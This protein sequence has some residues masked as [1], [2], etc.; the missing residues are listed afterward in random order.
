M[1]WSSRLG[2][3]PL[4]LTTRVMTFV[5][6]AIGLSLLVIGYLVDNAVE[7]HFA[8]QDAGELVVMMNAVDNA[9]RKAGDDSARMDEALS[10]A[11][12]GHHGVYFQVWDREKHLIY[13]P[14][15]GDLANPINTFAPVS[16]IQVGNLYHWRGDGKTYRGTIM[17]TQVGGREYTIVTAIDMDAHIQFLENFRRSLWLIMTLAGTVTLLAA[18]Y[19]VHQGHA[20]LRGLSETMSE[21]QADRLHVRLDPDNVPG[22]LQRLVT[23]FN[24]MIGRLEDSF[25]RLFHFSADIAHEMRTPLT[26]IITQ[27]QVILGKSRSLDEYGVLGIFRLKK[28]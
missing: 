12:S 5:A 19:G 2:K 22:E 21:I 11:V 6:L 24:D 14:S 7:H 4:S 23:S 16:S 18:W 15:E 28:T 26:N 1:M 17:Q 3:R 10:H 27:T 8:E 20:P 25:V 9:L 13:G